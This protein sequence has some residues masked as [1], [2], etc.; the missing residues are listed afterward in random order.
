[1]NF[2]FSEALKK[3]V[4]KLGLGSWAIGG[5]LWGGSNDRESSAAI[6]E[7][8]AH[9]VNF[10]DT[11]PIYGFGKAESLIGKVI[12]SLGLRESIILATKCGLEWNEKQTNIR[13]NS[14]P[15]RI[16]K[17]ID[18]SRYRL[19][20]DYIDLYQIHWPD[21]KTPFWQSLETLAKLQS[22]NTIR[23][24]GLS[25]FSLEQLESC[26]KVMPIQFVQLPYNLYEREIE[27]E[28]LSFCQEKNIPVL[29]YGGLCRG[30]LTGKFSRFSIIKEDDIRFY[31]PKFK[32]DCI[33]KYVAANRSLNE[34]A[35]SLKISLPQL[36]LRWASSRKGI[37]SML[38]G[39]RSAA[40]AKENFG[41]DL[42]P[43]QSDI[44]KEIDQ[45]LTVSVPQ[46]IGVEFM[47]PSLS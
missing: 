16:R 34:I 23:A 7:A 1:M 20:T 26:L 17:E 30:L 27:K 44:H 46:P 28:M 24:I 6:E 43:I 33:L 38:V 9:G 31:D 45:I 15:E 40:Q 19:Q 18:E 21:I 5:W 14:T 37:G 11:A 36:A 12:A 13:R 22:Q 47:A 2:F 10:I 4:S 29:G 25:N 3:D 39:V 35:K 41:F 32:A 42:T 8:L